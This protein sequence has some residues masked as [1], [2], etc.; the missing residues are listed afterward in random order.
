MTLSGSRCEGLQCAFASAAHQEQSDDRQVAAFRCVY[1]CGLTSLKGGVNG[2]SLIEGKRHEVSVTS[3]SRELKQSIPV[4][5]HIYAPF[6]R[7]E[8]SGL[9]ASALRR[10]HQPVDSR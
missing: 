4:A 1:E 7:P 6:V 5:L 8:V 10:P 9:Q 3:G 2:C